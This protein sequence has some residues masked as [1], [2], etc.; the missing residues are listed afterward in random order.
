MHR[1]LLILGC[2]L[3]MQ[4][5]AQLDFRYVPTVDPGKQSVRREPAAVSVL[6]AMPEKTHVTFGRLEF[7]KGTSSNED[8]IALAKARAS[9]MGAEWIVVTDPKA[10]LSAGAIPQ[11]SLTGK[12][13]GAAPVLVVTLGAYAV[14]GLGVEYMSPMLTG[15]R[16]VVGR[17]LPG[18]KAGAAGLESGD[19]IL[20]VNGMNIDDRHK[21]AQVL[22]GF[23]PGQTAEV[24]VKRAE[25]IL[26]LRIPLV[27][28]D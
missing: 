17:I 25:K 12:T 13:A 4:A 10:R 6:N 22:L 15:G 7:L 5:L 8:M 27:A 18:S 2:L 19:E 14:A 9:E 26:N 28:S 23:R 24:A 3:P 11:K 20:T 21:N 1:A 16:R